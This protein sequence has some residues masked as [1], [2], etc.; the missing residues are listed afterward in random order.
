M[1]HN[2]LTRRKAMGH[3]YVTRRKAMGHN[4]VKRRHST[5][6]PQVCTTHMSIHMSHTCV[7]THQYTCVCACV[8]TRKLACLYTCLFTCLYTRIYT[9]LYTFLYTC[10]YTCPCACRS[11]GLDLSLHEMFVA[12]STVPPPWIPPHPATPSRHP[13]PRR[14]GGRAG[15]ARPAAHKS[16]VGIKRVCVKQHG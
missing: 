5:I 13:I 1:D 16:R 12:M 11:D 2:C 10:L 15:P 8:Y 7:H 9:C 6:V 3:N 14:A 4:Y